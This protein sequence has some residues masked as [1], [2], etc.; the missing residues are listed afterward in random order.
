MTMPSVSQI[1]EVKRQ[2]FVAT[3]TLAFAN[4]PFMR[5]LLP[6]SADYLTKFPGFL[7]IEGLSY[8]SNTIQRLRPMALRASPFGS[9]LTSM[10][11]K[12]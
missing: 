6:D 9:H 1:A 11:M 3:L 8:P 7:E 5:W 10:G 12:T 4:D 2:A